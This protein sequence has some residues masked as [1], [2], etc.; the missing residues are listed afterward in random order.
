M[1]RTNTQWQGQRPGNQD[2]KQTRM[3]ARKARHGKDGKDCVEPGWQPTPV[4]TAETVLELT[5]LQVTFTR[6]GPKPRLTVVAVVELWDEGE[7]TGDLTIIGD[8]ELLLLQLTE[9]HILKL[10][11]QSKKK[12]Q[13]TLV[14]P[15]W[16]TQGAP[17]PCSGRP[18]LRGAHAIQNSQWKTCQEAKTRCPF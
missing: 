5:W 2:D 13:L 17:R 14:P 16:G 10:K 7:V 1:T 18:R 4:H 8:L 3:T 9:L 11:L 12:T 15:R 6:L